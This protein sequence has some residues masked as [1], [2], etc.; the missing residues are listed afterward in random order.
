[1]GDVYRPNKKNILPG[2]L[3]VL[4]LKMENFSNFSLYFDYDAFPLCTILTQLW[5]NI[6]FE[7]LLIVAAWLGKELKRFG[8]EVLV[9]KLNGDNSHTE[10]ERVTQ[11]FKERYKIDTY[12]DFI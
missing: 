4:K 9:L 7:T 11:L 12:F 10:K 6:Q 3:K 5:D 2:V 1:M 8:A